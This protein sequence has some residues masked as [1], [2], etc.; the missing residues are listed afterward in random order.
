MA[1]G[2]IV[3]R[4]PRALRALAH[5]VRLAILERLHRLDP[6]WREASHIANAT[7]RLTP[8]EAVELVRRMDAVVEP[9][10]RSVRTDVPP[11]ARPV[12]LLVRLFPR[13]LSAP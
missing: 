11:E 8:G 9:C 12:R 2:D 3:L 6:E 5:P 1:R 13:D 7:L 4:D 10:L